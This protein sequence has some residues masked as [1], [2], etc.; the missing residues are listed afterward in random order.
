MNKNRSGLSLC[1]QGTRAPRATFSKNDRFIPVYT[2]NTLFRRVLG[3]RG[4][5][6]PCV[7]REHERFVSL[8]S[9]YSGLSLCIQGTPYY[10]D[11]TIDDDRFIPVYTGNTFLLQPSAAKNTVYPCVYREHFSPFHLQNS[12]GGLSLCIQGTRV[13]RNSLIMFKPVY[14]CVYREHIHEC[15]ID[16]KRTGL[17]LCI[18]GTH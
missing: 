18:Q 16:F 3:W 1:I 12:N 15:T 6:Y 9:E 8:R 17:S 5:V 13:N 2:G 14:P 11:E 7:Y 10:G 4:A